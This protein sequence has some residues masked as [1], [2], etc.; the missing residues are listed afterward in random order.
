MNIPHYEKRAPYSFKVGSWILAGLI[1]LAS[2]I[3]KYTPVQI[4][5]DDAIPLLNWIFCLA[6]TIAVSSK[7]KV[8][9]E[10]IV[11][12]RALS[13]M[14]GF[15]ILIGFI[16]LTQLDELLG[17]R[18]ERFKPMVYLTTALIFHQVY[19]YVNSYLPQYSFLKI[20]GTKS[21]KIIITIVIVLLFQ[22][23]VWSYYD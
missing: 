14:A 20:G 5:Y 21:G 10:A 22:S 13:D 19:F 4:G 12:H 1:V 11:M 3:L 7:E 17:S 23:I 15:G 16:L 6:L 9:D 18:L 2:L 8:E